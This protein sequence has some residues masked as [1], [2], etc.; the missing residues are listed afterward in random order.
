MTRPLKQQVWLAGGEILLPAGRTYRNRQRRTSICRSAIRDIR[1]VSE[2]F[3]QELLETGGLI[4][5]TVN[6]KRSDEEAQL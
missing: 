6:S 3:T 1:C 2:Q 4:A 5:T